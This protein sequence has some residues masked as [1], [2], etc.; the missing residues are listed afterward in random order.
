MISA[1]VIIVLV[2]TLGFLFPVISLDNT[3]WMIII[4]VYIL[5]ASVAP[6]GSCCSRAIISQATC[7]TA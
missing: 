4:G 5:L 2:V 1:I 6:C 3:T 7:F